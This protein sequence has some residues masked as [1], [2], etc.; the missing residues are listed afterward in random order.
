MQTPRSGRV[1]FS[2]RRAGGFTLDVDMNVGAVG[3]S[4]NAVENISARSI[5]CVDE[6]DYHVFVQNFSKRN[7]DDAGYDIEVEFLGEVFN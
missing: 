7:T 3:A 2:Q 5:N 6:G 4:K 1:Y